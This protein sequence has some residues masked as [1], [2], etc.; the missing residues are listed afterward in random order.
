[1]NNPRNSS[2]RKRYVKYG[3]VGMTALGL[4]SGIIVFILRKKQGNILKKSSPK[5]ILDILHST[6]IFFT[7]SYSRGYISF[8]YWDDERRRSNNGKIKTYKSFIYVFFG[9][10]TSVQWL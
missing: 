4:L 7:E 5:A 9:C 1:M 3:L 6:Y 8:L 2:D 10:Y